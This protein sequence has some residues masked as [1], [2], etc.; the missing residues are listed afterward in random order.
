MLDINMAHCIDVMDGL[1][2]ISDNTADIIICDPPYNIRKDFGVSKDDMDF[3]EYLEWCDEWIDE[4]IRILKPSGTMFIYG[5]SE[6]L[7]YIFTRV[8]LEKRWLIWH[9]TNKTTPSMKFWQ[10]SFESII[11][12]WKDKEQRVF[13]T[14]DVR[15]QYTETF[16]RVSAG[17]KRN[18][19]KGRFSKGDKETIYNANKYGA[20]PRD[21]IKVP[22]LAGGSGRKERWYLCKD[23]EKILYFK[24]LNDH[25]DHSV[26]KHCTQKPMAL[27]NKLIKSCT[28]IE[29]PGFVVIPFI[30][31]GVEAICALNNS[32]DFIGFD[33]NNDY[34]KMTNLLIN[35]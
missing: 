21:V 15:E 14:D 5:L 35:R 28:P 2:T 18:S 34:V 13:N 12:C 17:R 24:D 22:T 1:K 7:A 3:D 26:I 9:Y 27:T 23:C 4:C 11:A 25:K 16:L 10:H 33:N 31:S 6:K 8:N 29:K 32:C 19:T 30:G 20:L